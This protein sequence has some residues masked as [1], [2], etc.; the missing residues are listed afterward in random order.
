MRSPDSINQARVD[1]MGVRAAFL[2]MDE[3]MCE[4]LDLAALTGVLVPLEHY[5]AT[6]DRICAIVTD[7]LKAPPKTIPRPIELHAKHLLPGFDDVARLKVL[8][9]AVDLVNEGGL[10]VF[11]TAYLNRREIH[12]LL[13]DDGKLYGPNFFS[14]LSWLQETM[15]TT[16]VLP[17][18]DGV[19]GHAPESRKRLHIDPTLI[20]AFAQQVRSIHHFRQ[21][22]P[23]R[24]MLSIE[25]AENLA[26][27]MIADSEHSVLLQ[28]VDLISHLLLQLE[29]EE[30]EAGFNPG[31]FKRSVLE[32]ARRLNPDL[33]F[34]WKGRLTMHDPSAPASGG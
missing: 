15:K 32:C 3:C 33:V 12:Q 19:P 23:M 21:Y 13:V 18:M 14:V 16:L 17:V 4:P 24:Q 5:A 26:E 10:Q 25:N 20:R 6:R 2:F 27:P 1:S 22:D 7:V 8:N 30:L 9:A 28:L 29:R 11:R 31:P 34:A